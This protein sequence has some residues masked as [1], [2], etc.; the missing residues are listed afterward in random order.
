[1]A[2][3]IERK[4]LVKGPFKE[5]ASKKM[6]FKQGYIPTTHACNVRIRTEDDKAFITIKGPGNSSG[7]SRFEWNHEIP[8]EEARDLFQ[9][10]ENG[11][12]EKYRYLIPVGNHV[13]EVDEFLGDN[14][15]LVVAEIE[16]SS[17]NEQF[18]KPF[19]LGQEVTG[20]R[21]YYNASL[22]RNPY[23]KW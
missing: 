12:I 4:F 15:G 11:L 20:I 23:I 17:E 3:E 1:M 21:N 9:F 13:F 10:C 8:L 7:M 16:L 14:A 2:I 6:Y 22:S 19:W 18:E 5:L